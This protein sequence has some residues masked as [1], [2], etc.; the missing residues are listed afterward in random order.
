M[1]LVIVLDN[2]V[3]EITSILK[4]ETMV[5]T[6]TNDIT[7]IIQV[8]DIEEKEVTK[9]RSYKLCDLISFKCLNNEG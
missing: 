2:E 9:V 4:Y 3:I 7:F 6:I 1:N 8:L 5:N